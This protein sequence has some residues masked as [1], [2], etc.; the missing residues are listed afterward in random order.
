MELPELCIKFLLRLYSHLII[1]LS[2]SRKLFVRS[3]LVKGTW[4]HY[5]A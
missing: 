4:Q 5:C 1:I 3:T 2:T